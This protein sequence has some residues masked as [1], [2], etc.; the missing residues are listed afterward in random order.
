MLGRLLVQLPGCP[1]CLAT[2]R[3]APCS[4]VLR[5][6]PY[7]PKTRGMAA[8]KEEAMPSGQTALP[9]KKKRKR[10][11]KPPPLPPPPLPDP[12]SFPPYKPS[13]HFRFELIHQSKKSAA[14]VGRIHTPHGVIDTPGFVAVGTN[15]ALKAVD[16][17]WADAEGLQ[18]MFCNTYHLL[19]HPGPEVVAGAGGLHAFMG[20]RDRPLITDSGG[21]QVFSLAYGTVHEEVNELK[22]S[23]GPSKHKTGN[24]MKGVT[25]EGVR[26]CSYRDG[27]HMLLTPESS[28]EAQKAF[29]A[30]IILPLDELPPYHI[31]DADLEASLGRSHRWM[32]RSLRT[33]LADPRRQAMY[34]IVH[35]GMSI[36][37]R[38]RSVEYLSALP[39]DGFAV[40]G[41]MGKD[42]EDMVGLLRQV[43][44]MMPRDKP[45]HI[46]GI[47]DPAT[48]P[49]L[50]PFGCDT[51]DS[52]YPTRAGRHG[53]ML[54][55]MGNVR[56][57]SGKF[58]N[59]HHPPVEG[60]TCYTCKTHTLAYLHHLKKAN[61]PLMSTL[62]TIHNIHFMCTLMSDLRQ[63][64]LADEI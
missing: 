27:S 59:A 43:M 35:G 10:K 56:V 64:I 23:Q 37:L 2:Y 61:E 6:R 16:G 7:L 19:L 58:K 60:C 47:A 52:C 4:N 42:R 48:L 33:H 13:P 29:G 26:F 31:A 39:F 17:A 28:V 57:I 11:E 14:R 18:L 3:L 51:F 9:A 44:P 25:E 53:T 8:D 62:L 32:A 30:D 38:R 21:F 40:G 45:C 22:R 36:D 15:A 34:G 46:L 20:R 49:Q 63:Q 24:L 54:T 50:V 5:C 41:S 55:P 12:S 1:S